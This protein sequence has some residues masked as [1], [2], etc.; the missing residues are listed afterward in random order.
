[1]ANFQF[2]ISAKDRNVSERYVLI[3]GTKKI[4][5]SETFNAVL[6]KG[7]RDMTLR[8]SVNGDADRRW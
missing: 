8:H 2:R 4:A 7:A 1:M 5:D 6:K 3:F